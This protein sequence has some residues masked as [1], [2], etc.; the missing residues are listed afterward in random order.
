MWI[1][2]I[3]PRATYIKCLGSPSLLVSPFCTHLLTLVHSALATCYANLLSQPNTVCSYNLSFFS[4]KKLSKN[5]SSEFLYI[6]RFFNFMSRLSTSGLC[7]RSNVQWSK[8][9]L[10]SESF[11]LSIS[12]KKYQIPILSFFNLWIVQRKVFGTFLGRFEKT[13]KT[14]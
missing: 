14:F 11:S 8:G 13:W 1:L 4:H 7:T 3:A 2:C 6:N 10:I 5:R 9:G 12:P